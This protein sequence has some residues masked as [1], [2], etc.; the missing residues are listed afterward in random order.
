MLLTETHLQAFD[1]VVRRLGISAYLCGGSVRDMLLN[2]PYHDIDVVLS[3]HVFEAAELFRAKLH[4]PSFVLDQERQV[5]RV[6]LEEGDW[7]FSGFRNGTIEGDLAMRDFTIN[8]LAVPWEDYFPNQ[9][10]T[11][12]IDPFAGLND[13]RAGLIRTVQPGSL[14]DDPLR[15]LRAFRIRAELHFRIDEAALQ[16][17]EQDHGLIAN[18]AAERITEELNRMMLQPDSADTW[19]QLGRSSLFDSIFPELKAMKGCE[20]G[21]YHHRDVWGHT[22]LALDTCEKMLAQLPSFFPDHVAEVED[23]LNSVPGTLERRR[24]LKWAMLLHDAGKP[25]TRELKEPGRWRFHGHDHAGADLSLMLLKRMKFA[26]KDSQLISL[27]IDHHLRP[28]NLFNQDERSAD[29]YY[30]FFRSTGVEAIAVLLLGYGDLSAARGLLA[31]PSRDQEFLQML[32]DMVTYYYKEYYPAV[33][34]PELIKGR[35][36][37]GFLQMKPGPLV[38]QLLKEIREQQLIGVLRDRDEALDFAS[39]W[40]KNKP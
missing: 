10:L 5:A 28:L 7:D 37:I 26:R 40:L 21:G 22:V 14:T 11:R 35:D 33:S 18:V 36:L 15:M 27:I 2:R 23:Y 38:G 29:D 31:D 12:V 39:K 20:Q 4:A 32:R 25:Q 24:L 6:V 1:A 19:E 30:R 34:T 9:S 17:I 3:D 16:R 13:L 8:A